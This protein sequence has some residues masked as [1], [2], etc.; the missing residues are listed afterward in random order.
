SGEAGDQKLK[1]KTDAEQHR[2]LE[3]DLP[4][5]HRTDPVE[6]LD[7]RRNTHDHRSYREKAVGVG[8]HPDGEHVVR[9]HAHAHEADTDRGCDHDWVS[10]NRFSGKYRNDP[11][12]KSK[13][14]NTRMYTSGCPNIQKKCIQSVADPPACVSKKWPPR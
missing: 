13:G 2:R 5:P 10:E 8:I 1:Q 7:S 6:D 14:G 11:R 9:P 3:L 4:A 12:Y